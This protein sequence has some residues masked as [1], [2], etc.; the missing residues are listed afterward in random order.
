VYKTILTDLTPKIQHV[1]RLPNV[2]LFVFKSS[3]SLASNSLATYK[4]EYCRR[5]IKIIVV[6][7]CMMYERGYQRTIVLKR[8]RTNNIIKP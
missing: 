1:G 4:Y 7:S 3:N 6:T 8:I 5:E 2:K